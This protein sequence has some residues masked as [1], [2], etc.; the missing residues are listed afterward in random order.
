V[1]E[2]VHLA[3]LPGRAREH[4]AQRTA[5]ALVGV[6]DDQLHAAQP[7]SREAAAELQPERLGLAGADREPEHALL[8]T[9]TH[10]HGN[11]GGLADDARALTHLLVR[12]VEPDI[13]VRLIERA[14]A[15]LGEL[16]I[17][18]RA[19]PAHLA[20]TDAAATQGGHEVVDLARGR[21]L[22]AL[23]PD[24]ARWSTA[25]TVCPRSKEL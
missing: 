19:D 11:H 24:G 25:D 12:G 20:A 15:E 14:I 2:E 6:G 10:A 3:A 21:P 22:A 23:A 1:A 5:Q 16:L 7:A 8:A 17:E 4:L 18:Q 13:R 9:V